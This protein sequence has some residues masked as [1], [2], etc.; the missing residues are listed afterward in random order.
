MNLDYSADDLAFR[1]EV[2]RWLQDNLPA[3]L[4]EK[5]TQ[6]RRLSKDELLRWHRILG[7]KGWIAPAWPVFRSLMRLAGI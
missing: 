1:D 3:D 7:E 2:T 6:C 4:R 5:V